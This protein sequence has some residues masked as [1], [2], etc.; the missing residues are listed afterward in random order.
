LAYDL[1]EQRL[2]DGTATSQEVTHFLKAG[3]AREK[4]EQMKLQHDNE[5][6][7]ARIEGLAAAS[8]I[9][10]LYKEAIKWMRT[11][12][13]HGPTDPADEYDG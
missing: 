8:R 9:E 13:G 11:Y 1:A 5:L 7:Q 12:S 2:R 4:L 10:D 6:T 3:S